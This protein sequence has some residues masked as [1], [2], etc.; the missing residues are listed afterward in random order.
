MQMTDERSG[1]LDDAALD[2]LLAQLRA[3]IGTRSAAVSRR[4]EPGALVKF[5]KA[6]GQ[7]DPLYLQEAHGPLAPPTYLSTFCAEG[8][9]GVFAVDLPLKMF[10]HTDDA[11]DMGEPIRGGDTITAAGELVDVILKHGKRGP[12]LFQTGEITMTN[13]HY[14]RVATVRVS[15]VNFQ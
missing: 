15:M 11:V 6:T 13:Q 1:T 5:A 12:M 2:A 14:E 4:I 3:R 7:T 10:L 8:L 9:A